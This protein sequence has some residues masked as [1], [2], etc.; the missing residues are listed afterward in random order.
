MPADEDYIEV[1]IEYEGFIAGRELSEII[2]VL[3][4]ALW[5]EIENTFPLPFR[6]SYFGRFREPP[7][8]FCISEANRGSLLLTGVIGGAAAT[9]C[10]NRFKRGFR[11][12]RFGAQVEHF[13]L[14]VGD[15][16]GHAIERMNDWLEDYLA[17]ARAF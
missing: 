1:I 9:Y 17:E 15:N 10:F 8:L 14:L 12:S 16:L 7:P 13:G 11:R 6:S 2:E 4:E 3:D 5:Y